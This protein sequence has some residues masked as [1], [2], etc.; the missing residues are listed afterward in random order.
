MWNTSFLYGDISP[1]RRA[2]GTPVLWNTDNPFSIELNKELN[3]SWFFIS[4]VEAQSGIVKTFHQPVLSLHSTTK[5]DL[6]CWEQSSGEYSSLQVTPNSSKG[7]MNFWYCVW[8]AK[9]S[10]TFKCKAI[11]FYPFQFSMF[12]VLILSKKRAPD[13]GAYWCLFLSHRR[14]SCTQRCLNNKF[15]NACDVH[16]SD[17]QNVQ[18][19]QQQIWCCFTV[20]HRWVEKLSDRIPLW[21]IGIE[22]HEIK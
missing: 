15:V 16:M 7:R 2:T 1:F 17:K 8:M 6:H 4:D 11:C 13:C 18:T 19:S 21:M 3:S 14:T 9:I 20:K 5:L 12:T 22:E 10:K